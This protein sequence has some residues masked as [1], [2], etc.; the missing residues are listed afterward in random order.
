MSEAPS[1]STPPD[2]S[3]TLELR[4]PDMDC[5]TC[6]GKV[7][8]SVGRLDGIDGIDPRVTSGR[9]VVD[10]DPTLT[11]ESRIRERVRAAG[12]E[13]DGRAA[14]RTFSV[15]GMDCASCA[16]KVENALERTDGVDDIE[17]R[18]AS[19]RVTVTVADGADSETV[20]GAI[21]SAGYDA[22]P[23][24]DDSDPIDDRDSVWKSRRAVGTAVGAV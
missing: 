7:E 12:Y 5:P 24:A 13:I 8:N 18:P 10:Y 15:P 2:S 6:A 20:L 14:E 3:R 9:L 21:E 1:P 17:T 19:G 4:V 16:S 23:A 11:D 22:S